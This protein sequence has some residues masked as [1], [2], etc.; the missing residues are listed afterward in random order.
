MVAGGRA[1]QGPGVW[2]HTWPME[3][4]GCGPSLVRWGWWAWWKDPALSHQGTGA[5]A[6]Q[7]AHAHV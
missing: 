6:A 1:G 2:G 7:L 5:R 4:R 3:A